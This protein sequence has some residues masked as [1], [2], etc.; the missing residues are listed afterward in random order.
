M[1]PMGYGQIQNHGEPNHLVPLDRHR[2]LAL[3]PNHANYNHVF[4]R[5]ILHP[6]GPPVPPSKPHRATPVQLNDYVGNRQASESLLSYVF[7]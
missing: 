7:H 6:K 1:N 5:P 3:A 2:Q 4:A